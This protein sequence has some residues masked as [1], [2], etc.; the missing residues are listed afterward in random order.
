MKPV[1]FQPLTRSVAVLLAEE[2]G[3]GDSVA[4]QVYGEVG[5]WLGA[6]VIKYISIFE[7]NRLILG[8]G[9]LSASELLLTQV[10]NALVTHS[11]AR[12]CSMVEVVPARLGGDAALIGAVVPLL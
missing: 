7:P 1:P 5:R 10:R 11:S 3:R 9:V 4:L 6:A 8:W 12:V 2:A